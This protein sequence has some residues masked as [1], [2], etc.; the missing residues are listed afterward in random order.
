MII[1]D[2]EETVSVKLNED[3]KIKTVYKGRKGG[4]WYLG[5]MLKRTNIE[6]KKYEAKKY[7]YLSHDGILLYK[8]K[9]KENILYVYDTEEKMLKFYSQTL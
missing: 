7:E 2:N 5:N 8:T 4:R 9:N 1:F 3:V 6:G